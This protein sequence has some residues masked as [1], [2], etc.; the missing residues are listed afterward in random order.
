[1]QD[2]LVLSLS[3]IRKPALDLPDLEARLFGKNCLIFG[4]QVRMVNIVEE[5][6]LKN[7]CLVRFE[8]LHTLQAILLNLADR[9]LRATEGLHSELDILSHGDLLV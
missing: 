7:A 6:F 2:F 9:T 4:S 1:M 8:C 3:V 5:P